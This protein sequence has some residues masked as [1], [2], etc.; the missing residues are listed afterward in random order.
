MP[1]PLEEQ[2][3][4]KETHTHKNYNKHDSFVLNRIPEVVGPPVT[5]NQPFNGLESTHNSR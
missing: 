4:M 1:I 3:V 2:G 5:T